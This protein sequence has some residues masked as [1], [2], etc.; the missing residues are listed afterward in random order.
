MAAGF[1]A[2][3]LYEK[4]ENKIERPT[5]STRWSVRLGKHIEDT[6]FPPE[7]ICICTV[8]GTSTLTGPTVHKSPFRHCGRNEEVPVEV[9]RQYEVA[10]IDWKR[11]HQPKTSSVDERRDRFVN[12][13]RIRS[14]E[15]V[16]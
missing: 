16:K 13:L 8:C 3:G 5:P 11:K 4:V 14:G 7:L 2:T 10:R 15:I 12:D 1:L 9:Q 6:R